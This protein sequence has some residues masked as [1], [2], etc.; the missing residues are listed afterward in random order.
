M[1]LYKKERLEMKL[2]KNV[3]IQDLQSILKR[4]ILSG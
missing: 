2:Y 3:D 1:K 4:G